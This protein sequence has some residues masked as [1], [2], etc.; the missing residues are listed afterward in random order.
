MATAQGTA[1][2]AL[3]MRTL[4]HFT[5]V[6]YWHL[7]WTDTIAKGSRLVE[8]A[9]QAADQLSEVSTRFWVG[10]ALLNTGESNEARRHV[11]PMLSSAESLRSRYWQATAYWLNERA[12]SYEGNWQ[13]AKEFN[14]RGLLV[15]PSD[16]RLPR[17]R[18]RRR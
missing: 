2:V 10:I 17:P 9:R 5:M 16:T 4:A 7:K 11:A 1:D 15:S 6:D 8:L 14:E 12:S 18:S 3:E 13:A